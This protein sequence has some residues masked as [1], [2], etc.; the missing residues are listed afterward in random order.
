MQLKVGWLEG[1]LLVVSRVWILW[2][3]YDGAD[4]ERGRGEAASA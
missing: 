4:V 3:S 2:M 1:G